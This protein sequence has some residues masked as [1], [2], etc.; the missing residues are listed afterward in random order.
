MCCPCVLYSSE[1]TAASWAVQGCMAAQ[2]E[3]LE[4][5]LYFPVLLSKEPP[6]QQDQ[7]TSESSGSHER[8]LHAHAS[9]AMPGQRRGAL[10]L[11]LGALLLLTSTL[12]AAAQGEGHTLG[13]LQVGL[14][15]CLPLLRGTHISTGAG[16][17]LSCRG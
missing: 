3:R 7:S 10:L 12:Q 17:W 1:I 15:R 2:L 13:L 5:L 8:A 14:W 11:G 16:P 6:L 9:P 4:S